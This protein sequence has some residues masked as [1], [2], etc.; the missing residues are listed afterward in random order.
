MEQNKLT[1]FLVE[2]QETYVYDIVVRAKDSEDAHAIVEELCYEGVLKIGEEPSCLEE[3][4]I[5][6]IRHASRAELCE[7][8]YD[9]YC[10]SD[11]EG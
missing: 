9:E 7:R 4:S 2:V 8:R 1:P 5:A 6:V 10:R 11:L 3:R